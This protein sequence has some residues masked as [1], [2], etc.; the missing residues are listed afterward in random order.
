MPTT[1]G[2][3]PS[4]EVLAAQLAASDSAIIYVEIEGL[5]AYAAEDMLLADPPLHVEW[6]DVRGL[7]AVRAPSESEVEDAI[8]ASQPAPVV[9]AAPSTGSASTSGSKA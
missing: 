7:W 2:N 3:T 9:V 5:D 6:D 4:T 1:K 8:L